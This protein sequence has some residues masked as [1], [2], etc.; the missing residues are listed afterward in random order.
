MVEVTQRIQNWVDTGVSFEVNINPDLQTAD[1]ISDAFVD[2]FI[3]GSLKTIYYSLTIG[4]DDDLNNKKES[5]CP[6]C[7]N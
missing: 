7:A 6:D 1:E 2:G 5:S 3:N 4:K